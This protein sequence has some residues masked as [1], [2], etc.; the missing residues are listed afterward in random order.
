L[1]KVPLLA[2]IHQ[3]KGSQ[4]FQIII[5]HSRLLQTNFGDIIFNSQDNR[6]FNIILRGTVMLFT[7]D[8]KQD[9][10]KFYKKLGIGEH[11]G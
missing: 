3:K 11:F 5:Q 9:E 8:K 2:L 4:N 6:T 1:L 7:K 10:P